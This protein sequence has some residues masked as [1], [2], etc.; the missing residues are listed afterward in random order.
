VLSEQ[1][2]RSAA[3]LTFSRFCRFDDFFCKFLSPTHLRKKKHAYFGLGNLHQEQRKKPVRRI[4][5]LP[6]NSEMR[7]LPKN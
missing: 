7:H 2:G 1:R 5:A 3:D 4:I 6:G